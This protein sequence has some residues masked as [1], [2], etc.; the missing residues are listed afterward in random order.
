MFD[1]KA[2][3]QPLALPLLLLALL[4]TSV[5]SAA[6]EPAATSW[7]LQSGS[8][9]APGQ[10]QMPELQMKGQV[11]SGST[12]CNT[13]TATLSTQPDGRV[14]IAHLTMSRKLCP[15]K[16]KE[17]EI[18]FVEALGQTRF[19]EKKGPTLEFLSEKRESLLVWRSRGNS[20]VTR[21]MGTK[22]QA[23]RHKRRKLAAR[24][25]RPKARLM[26]TTHT[27]SYTR[28][29]K[30]HRVRHRHCFVWG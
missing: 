6:Q 20:E 16:Q 23:T 13:F 12:G 27:T 11:L 29:H 4:S 8:K 30:Q 9:I 2:L 14:G 21:S 22:R 19:L 3:R 28:R 5:P 18:A 1:L 26:R 15:P 10:L 25:R 24:T 17:V 7:T